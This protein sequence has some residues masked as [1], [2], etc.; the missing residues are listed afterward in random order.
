M[1]SAHHSIDASVANHRAPMHSVPEK[2]RPKRVNRVP[3][4]DIL[5]LIE[6]IKDVANRRQWPADLLSHYRTMLSKIAKRMR[7]IERLNARR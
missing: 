7:Y 3:I 5:S 2:H 1:S 6:S 4:A